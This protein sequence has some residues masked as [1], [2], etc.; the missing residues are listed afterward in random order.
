MQAVKITA[1]LILLLAVT[2]RYQPDLV[3]DY[4]TRWLPPTPTAFPIRYVRIEGVFQ[5]LSKDDIKATIEPLITQGFFMADMQNIHQA[6][7]ALP[8][9]ETVNIERVWPDALNVKV[10]EKK[11]YLRWGQKS[12]MTEKGIIFTPKNIN[13]FQHLILLTAPAQQQ[14]KALEIL[15]GVTMT[16]ADQTMQ[17]QEFN[18]NNRWS[19]KIKLATGLE[20]LLGRTEQLKKLQRFLKTLALLG[21]EQIKAMAIV[22]L[23]Y[24]NGY[25]VSWQADTAPINWKTIGALK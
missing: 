1:L 13:P 4:S 6:V 23:R 7:I 20:I 25:A 15:K 9:V 8:W 5:Y 3:K 14:K 24:P 10:S 12:L 11:P 17:L 16:L 18:I 21:Q 19:W 2:W 22:D